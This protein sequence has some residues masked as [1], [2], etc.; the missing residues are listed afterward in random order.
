MGEGVQKDSGVKFVNPSEFFYLT[1]TSSL[2]PIAKVS[3]DDDEDEEDAEKEVFMDSKSLDGRGPKGVVLGD[4]G[5][6]KSENLGEVVKENGVSGGEEDKLVEHSKLVTG[7]FFSCE[8]LLPKKIKNPRGPL[9]D[10]WHSVIVHIGATSSIN[11][12]LNSLTNG[13]MRLSQN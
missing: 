8:P 13:C 5:L 6:G 11:G 12:K 3:V 4:S 1:S 9:N 2:R 7:V 10:T